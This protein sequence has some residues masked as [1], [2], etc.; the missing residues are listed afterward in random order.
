MRRAAFL[1]AVWGLTAASAA[2]AHPHF[3]KTVSV[4]LPS[5]AEAIITYNTTPANE[6]RAANVAVGT[7]VTPRKP[8][9]KLSTDVKAGEVSIPAGEYTIGVIK[10]SDKDWTMALYPGALPQGTPD[11]AKALKLESA[12]STDHGVAEHMLIDITPGTGKLEGRAA[13]TLHFG[14]LFLAGALSPAA[15]PAPMASPRPSAPPARPAP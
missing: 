15:P 12:F 13:L 7:F 10:K 5:G 11:V 1:S 2:Y 3:N 14:N 6:T 9:L 4:T 8:M